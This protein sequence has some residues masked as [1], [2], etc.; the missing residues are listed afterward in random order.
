MEV[1]AVLLITSSATFKGTSLLSFG[2]F[3]DMSAT[4]HAVQFSIHKLM[5]NVM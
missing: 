2:M 3:Q 4:E 1:Q 5:V